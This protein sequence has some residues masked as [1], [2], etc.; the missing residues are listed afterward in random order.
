MTQQSI[1]CKPVPDKLWIYTH[2][3]RRTDISAKC[4]KTSKSDTPSN[5]RE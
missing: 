4:P 5:I 3:K 1:K 2:T